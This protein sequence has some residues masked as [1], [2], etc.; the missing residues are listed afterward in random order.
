MQDPC[1]I[2]P[3]TMH[4]DNYQPPKERQTS[5]ITLDHQRFFFN[6]INITIAWKLEDSNM[7]CKLPISYTIQS[8][9]CVT[10]S[11]AKSWYTTEREYS[12]PWSMFST[13]HENQ[14]LY[15]SIVANGGDGTKCADLPFHFQ[16]SFPGMKFFCRYTKLQPASSL[17]VAQT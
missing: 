14:T 2:D 5:T 7:P 17:N 8:S 13:D 9:T 3:S 4:A 12:F 10:G 6:S 1:D 11:I 16:L 15:F